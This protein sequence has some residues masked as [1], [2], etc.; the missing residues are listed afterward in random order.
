LASHR[1]AGIVL[2]GSAALLAPLLVP[3]LTGRVFVYN[4]LAWFHLP[5][6]HL[7]QQ[8]LE[9]GD[10]VLWTPS[11]YAGFYL[12]GEGQT[13]V[14]HPF[15]Q[16]LYRLFPLGT[17]FNIEIAASYLV[18]FAGMYWFLQ[19]LRVSHAAALFGAM[20]F[21]FSGFML[22]HHHH[23]NMGAVVAHLP[24]LLSAAD[25]A[26][27]DDRPRARTFALAGIAAIVGS[28]LLL[29]FPQAVWWS[30][31]A[32]AAYGAFRAGET[33]RWRRLAGCAAAIALGALVGAVQVL[34]TIEAVGGS[35]RAGLPR[36]FALSY[37]LHPTNLVQLWSPYFFARG[38]HSVGDYMW[39]HEFGIYS[40][41]IL[42]VA[43]IWVWQRRRA[44][45]ERRA[46]VT[47]AT[48][49]ACVM[50]VL[51]LGRYGGLAWILA[52]V[53]GLQS[54]RAPVRYIVLVQFSLAVLAA[55]AFDDLR[56]IVDGR[57]AAP[58]RAALLWTP[59]ALAVVTTIALNG[60]LLPFGRH[61]FASVAAAAPGVA[62]VLA[63]SLLV[64]L[65]SRRVRWALPALVVVTAADLA[66]WGIGFVSRETPLTI[67]ALTRGVASAPIEPADSYAA[68][69]E[70]GRLSHD[71]L[72]LRGYRLTNGY[73]GLVPASRHPFDGDTALRLSGTRWI[74]NEDGSRAPAGSSAARARLLDE[75]EEQATGTARLVV[76]RPGHLVV[77]V[78]TE[79]RHLLALTERFHSGWTAS[80]GGRSLP[81]QRVAGDFLG[82]V[83]DGNV[84]SVELRFRPRSVV[85]GAIASA[86]GLALVA[87]LLLWRGR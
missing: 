2:G 17:A 29:G 60:R 38:A 74:F 4:D 6:R 46:L 86:I 87:G 16:L 61:T 44:L 23:V 47:A 78:D 79:D 43:L 69:P 80:A 33:G 39:F 15:H 54:L 81:T 9:A 12:H 64:W 57:S 32:L 50:L 82:C 48:L 49:F 26:I 36:D 71:V 21:A 63:V 25:V 18:A 13:G 76:D 27:A 83:V 62:I 84:R 70:H 73:A 77:E 58:E 1:L 24:W 19:R 5:M 40:G 8:A 11:I 75:G 22:L 68:A 37:S 56:A 59:A 55:V 51:A 67:A 31:I 45:P 20:L 52:Y 3:L 66:A 7:Y 65:A 14:F 53:P 34:P 41:T 28:Q 35:V 85:Y 30:L 72:V 42:P 10:S